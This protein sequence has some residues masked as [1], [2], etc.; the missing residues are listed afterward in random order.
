MKVLCGEKKTHANPPTSQRNKTLRNRNVDKWWRYFWSETVGDFQTQKWPK[1]GV[2]QGVEWGLLVLSWLGL[3]D[4]GLQ[5]N[6]FTLG[7]ACFLLA[8]SCEWKRRLIK[9]N[10]QTDSQQDR[11]R[12]KQVQRRRK[13]RKRERE[14][15]RK[16][17]REKKRRKRRKREREKKPY[18]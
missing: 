14:K 8:A 5:I 6:R 9:H 12:H 11:E 3:V 2:V 18:L 4:D 15:E 17:E 16:R 13:E 1:G 7:I 10:I